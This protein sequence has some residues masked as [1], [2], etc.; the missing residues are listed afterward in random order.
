MGSVNNANGLANILGCVVS[1]L[2]FIGSFFKAKS[3]LDCVIEKIERHFVDW[4][5][6]YLSCLR[7]EGLP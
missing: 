5:M 6:M 7:V 2:S 4:K 1:S 3:I